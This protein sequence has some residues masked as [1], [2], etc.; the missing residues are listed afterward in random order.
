MQEEAL[1]RMRLAADLC[2]AIGSGQLQ[3]HYQPIVQLR[4]GQ[5]MKSEALVPWRHP[6][7]GMVSLG[8]FIPVTEDTGLIQ[9]LGDWFF[10]EVVCQV[11][12]W[13]ARY[14]GDFQASVNKSLI[15]FAADPRNRGRPGEQPTVSITDSQLMFDFLCLRPRCGGGAV[16]N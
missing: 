10:E 5:V 15:Q 8:R 6:V 13:R 2:T 1:A 11:K 9:P 12:H 3:V 4:T 14:G 16:F 7:L